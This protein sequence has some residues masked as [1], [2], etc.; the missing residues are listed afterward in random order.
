MVNRRIRRV[1]RREQ[2]IN[3]HRYQPFSQ[4]ST[5]RPPQHPKTQK[6]V[7]L[8][9]SITDSRD[10]IA[11]SRKPLSRRDQDDNGGYSSDGSVNTLSGRP[12]RNNDPITVVTVSLKQGLKIQRMKLGAEHP[13]VTRAMH[14]LALE[15]KTQGKLNK[16]VKLLREGID[17]L[18]ER[19]AAVINNEQENSHHD[20]NDDQSLCSTETRNSVAN[21]TEARKI[22]MILILEEKSTFYSC[23]GNIFRM[24]KLYR[25]AMDYYVKSCDMLVEAGYSG[26]SKRV[27]MMVRIMRRT[28]AERIRK[29]PVRQ[30]LPTIQRVNL[31]AL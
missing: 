23:L 4:A 3:P 7:V 9:K 11:V 18:D 14:S 5:S 24:R 1:N 21:A 19:L 13:S 15:Y 29:V 8:K 17:F 27:T 6:R 28:E 12:Y 10:D 16:S 20:Y 31:E 26:E 22:Q 30:N 2:N 25:E